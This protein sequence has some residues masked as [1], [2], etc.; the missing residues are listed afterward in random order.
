M[1]PTLLPAHH[2][3]NSLERMVKSGAISGDKVDAWKERLEEEETVAEWRRDAEAGQTYAMYNLGFAYYFGDNGLKED[4]AEAFRWFQRGAKA[5]DVD[6]L[7]FVGR[8]YYRGSGVARNVTHGFGLIIEAALGGSEQA[9]SLLGHCYA[10]GNYV[11]KNAGRATYWYR[12][13]ESC[14]SKNCS[15][16]ERAEAAEWLRDNSVE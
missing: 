11:T 6:S 8:C 16:Q 3:R 4:R 14:S 12:K 7:Y 5:G 15:A 1:G 13:M 10:V 2:V 9:C